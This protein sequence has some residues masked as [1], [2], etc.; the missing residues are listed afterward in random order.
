VLCPLPRVLFLHILASLASLLASWT[1]ITCTL[2]KENFPNNPTW[3][4]V[5]ALLQSTRL[6]IWFL[7][8]IPIWNYLVCLFTCFYFFLPEW[9]LHKQGS[10]LSCTCLFS[11]LPSNSF[12]SFFF[13]YKIFVEL[14]GNVSLWPILTFLAQ[15]I[16]T[17]DI[18]KC[19]FLPLTSS[20]Y[21]RNMVR[22]VFWFVITLGSY[23]WVIEKAA[24]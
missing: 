2:L 8:H 15:F 6:F 4:T 17:K 10:C 12:W 23:Q 19:L 13:I 1:Q 16:C 20:K 24:L 7:T 18:F 11:P 14:R 5:L 22:K 3:N 9:K 21:G